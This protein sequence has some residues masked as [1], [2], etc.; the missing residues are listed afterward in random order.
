MIT[1]QDNFA[2]GINYW[3][4]R[5]AM[6]WWKAF[7]VAEVERDFTVL[8]S[9]GVQQVRIFLTWEDFQPRPDRIHGPSL[10]NLLITA[11]LAQTHDLC[12][13][14]TFFCG[15]MSGVNWIPDWALESGQQPQRFPVY[16][17]GNLNYRVIGN[18]Y[19]QPALK[20]AQLLQ[21]DTVCSALK[22]HPAV[23]AYD[24]G[25]ESSNCC[26]PPDRST[27]QQWL[28]AMRSAIDHAHPGSQVTLGMHAEDLEED[29]HLW[30]QDAARY[31]DFLSMHGYPF[32]LSWVDKE[33]VYLLPFLGIITSWLG[34]A[35]VLFQEF[36]WPT[37]PNDSG[38]DFDRWAS[39]KTPLWSEQ[40]SDEH[41]RQTLCLLQSTGMRGAFGWCFADYHPA[42]Y[43]KP[44]LRENRH[45]R[46]F[47]VTHWD[48]S[49]KPALSSL[50]SWGGQ[51]CLTPELPSWLLR[52]NQD[53]FYDDP[54]SNLRKW[55]NAYKADIANQTI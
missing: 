12:L 7:D 34:N 14:P 52:E 55:F 16:S 9:Y 50:G 43:D 20:E 3:P 28:A 32:Y 18:F 22:G 4:A 33:D 49:V 30:P 25:N 13:M 1:I 31:C 2:V 15:H 21:I 37:E 40:H 48:G 44:P 10:D 8:N 27:G 39:M 51:P 54:I 53:R 26:I 5:K 24:L 6:Y 23:N 45:E 11:D 29:R 17:Q 47:G 46:Y 35:P 41:Y 38:E 36:G 19:H 42:L